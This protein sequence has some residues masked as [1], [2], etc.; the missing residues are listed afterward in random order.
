MTSATKNLHEKRSARLE[1]RAPPSLK[2]D[3]HH[4]A[5]LM[6]MEDTSYAVSVLGE[7]ARATI[8]AHQRTRLSEADSETFLAALDVP[9]KPTKALRELFKLHRATHGDAD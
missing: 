8:E 1:F 5:T 6:G 3:I 4:A 9:A 2:A 7:H